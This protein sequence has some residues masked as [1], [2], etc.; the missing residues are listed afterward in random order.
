MRAARPA[1]ASP[2]SSAK[3]LACVYVDAS[4]AVLNLAM[5][6]PVVLAEALLRGERRGDATAAGCGAW[7]WL[8]L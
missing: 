3:S 4:D 7:R 1:L 6:L 5:G 2:S 8:H